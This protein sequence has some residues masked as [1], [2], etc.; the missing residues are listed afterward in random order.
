MIRKWPITADTATAVTLGVRLESLG[1]WGNEACPRTHTLTAVAVAVVVS[2]VIGLFR[3]IL[4][5]QF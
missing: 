4:S 5:P 3:I 2:V 1:P